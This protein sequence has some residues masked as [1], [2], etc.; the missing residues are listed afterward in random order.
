MAAGCV[1]QQSIMP[2]AVATDTPQS[3]ATKLLNGGQFA[4]AAA[5]MA[6]LGALPE[7]PEAAAYRLR[8]GLIFA[9]LGDMPRALTLLPVAAPNAP[10]SMRQALADALRLVHEGADDQ[11]LFALNSVD[12]ATFDPYE[13]GLFLRSLGRL[14]QRNG[15]QAAILNLLNAELFPMPAN[16]R[17]ELTHL[18]WEA[19]RINQDPGLAAKPDPRNP[20]L[21]GWLALQTDFRTHGGD[22]PALSTRLTDWRLRFPGHPANEIL[23]DE[24]LEFAEEQSAPIERVALLL[25]L[26]GE[27]AGYAS[28][29]RDGFNS[30]RFMSNDVA[31]IVRIY[32]AMG[33]AAPGVY[34][35]AVKDGAQ[36]IVGPLDKPA[37]EAIAKLSELPAPLLTLN[38]LATPLPATG[39]GGIPRFTQFGLS[40]E[41][42]GEDLANHA[43]RDGHRRMACIIPNTEL[44]T[45]IKTAFV[46]EWGRLGGTLVEESAYNNSVS[47]YKAS[48]RK[49]FSL[50]QSE[51]RAAQLRRILN[52]PIVFVSKPRPDLDAI[53]L[54]ADPIAARQIIPQFRYLG[55]DHLPIYATSQVFSGDVD[56]SADQDLDAVIFGAMPWSLG[57]QDRALRDTLNRHWPRLNA[58]ER[59]LFAFG[60]DAYRITKALPQMAQTSEHALA[61]ATGLLRRE[62]SGRI[63]R[64]LAW[65]VFRGGVPRLLQPQ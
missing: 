9:D 18:I 51:A 16:R 59:S 23:V 15:D 40:P 12:S 32:S 46:D 11:A 28:A 33:T 61:G 43:W 39:G 31:L 52:R 2:V 57:A 34:R 62:P 37:L 13:K 56:A 35:Q 22:P 53:M 45:R 20:N 10:S 65:A 60:M 49:T 48:I 6:T 55:V 44:G 21:S 36:L 41:D 38:N 8:A 24:I 54:V 19:L 4:E 30:M 47:D 3:R 26:D 50:A 14:Q 29:V 7:D 63:K 27:L 25:P 17:T 1:Q 42:E 58:T 64:A 5:A